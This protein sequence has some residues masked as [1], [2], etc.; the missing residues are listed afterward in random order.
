LFY[1]QSII[2]GNYILSFLKFHQYH[3]K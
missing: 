1:Q 2:P 3:Q